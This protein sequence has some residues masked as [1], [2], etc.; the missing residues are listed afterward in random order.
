MPGRRDASVQGLLVAPSNPKAILC[1]T[2]PFPHFVDHGR[3]LAGRVRR[4][5]RSARGERLFGRACGSLFV[6]LGMG[7]LSSAGR[8]SAR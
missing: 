3:P 7:L 4:W 2:A 5:L 8:T 6:V 1:F